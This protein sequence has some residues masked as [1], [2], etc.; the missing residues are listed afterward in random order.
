M[1]DEREHIKDMLEM[2]K[3]R[4][5]NDFVSEDGKVEERYLIE[6]Q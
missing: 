4:K 1:I 6:I 3:K 5:E 2:L